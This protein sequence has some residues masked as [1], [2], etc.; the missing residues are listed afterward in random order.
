MA[1][2]SDNY[3]SVSGHNEGSEIADANSPSNWLSLS[4]AD[5]SIVRDSDITRDSNYRSRSITIIFLGNC[6]VGKTSFVHYLETRA[7][8]LTL[9]EVTSAL[10]IRI[11]GAKVRDQSYSVR[12][13]D[14]AGV[15]RYHSFSQSY[16]RAADGV[17]LVYDLTDYD[18]FKD[19]N[20][21]KIEA[22][23]HCRVDVPFVLVGNK[24][25]LK[26]DDHHVGGES[27]VHDLEIKGGFYKTSSRTGQGIDEAV[28][29]MISLILKNRYASTCEGKLTSVETIRLHS[30]LSHHRC[31]C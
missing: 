29:C 3:E 21:W 1:E 23:E 14:T 9:L 19:I 4:P 22:E 16:Y 17:I 12:L 31:T 26:D 20:R 7:P 8:V 25:D 13:M 27:L 30:D 5:I 18:S 2:D 6:N 15:E 10:D 28:K 11:I 24:A